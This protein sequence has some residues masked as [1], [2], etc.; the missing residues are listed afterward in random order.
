[1]RATDRNVRM[2]VL[3]DLVYMAGD[4]AL[5]AGDYG[6]YRHFQERYERLRNTA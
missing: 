2:C 6:K 1:M 3:L 5:Q 4:R